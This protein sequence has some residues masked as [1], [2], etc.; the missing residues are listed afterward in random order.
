MPASFQ[1]TG[2]SQQLCYTATD[3][4]AISCSYSCSGSGRAVVLS[5]V[6]VHTCTSNQQH[7]KA[8]RVQMINKQLQAGVNLESSWPW[9]L[10]QRQNSSSSYQLQSTHDV[11][12]HPE[13]LSD[14]EIRWS[15]H[16]QAPKQ[17]WTCLLGTVSGPW[18]FLISGKS[19][20]KRLAG[21]GQNPCWGSFG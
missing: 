9:D 20:W 17:S 16:S 21:M 6:Y 10:A 15:L 13:K 7:F 2:C 18:E 12:T 14:S 4:A 5:P 11:W 8:D 19:G 3:T 1:D